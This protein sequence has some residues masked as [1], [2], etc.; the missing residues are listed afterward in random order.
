MTDLEISVALAKAIG[1]TTVKVKN[2]QFF[3]W[4]AGS[5]HWE[6][7]DYKDPVIAFRVAEKFDCFPDKAG[8]YFNEWGSFEPGGFAFH[9]A[10]TPQKAIALAVINGVKK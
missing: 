10:D 2:G 8:E 4:I 5:S 6:K 1:W 3:V 7:F 9:V